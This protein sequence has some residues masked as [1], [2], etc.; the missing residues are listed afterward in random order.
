MLD[1]TKE[2]IK[3]YQA[4]IKELQSYKEGILISK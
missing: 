1:I 4:L 3:Q 2:P